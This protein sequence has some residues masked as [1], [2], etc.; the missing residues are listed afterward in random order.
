MCD[1]DLDHFW[2]GFVTCMLTLFTANLCVSVA[3][4][5][6]NVGL[7]FKTFVALLGMICCLQAGTYRGQSVYTKSEVSTF[8]HFKDEKGDVG[9]TQELSSC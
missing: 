6:S 5:V 3:F 8:T 1:D 2:G 7:E 4:A 9:F